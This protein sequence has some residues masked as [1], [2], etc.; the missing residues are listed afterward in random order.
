[1]LYETFNRLLAQWTDSAAR[2]SA[3]EELI[4]LRAGTLIG[5]VLDGLRIDMEGAIEIL[6]GKN[7]FTTDLERRR[8]DI[9]VA[10]LENMIDFAAAEEYTLS[11]IHI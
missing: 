8:R 7:D 5:C 10:G 6:R 4:E 11:L 1:M 3:F 9:L 2:L